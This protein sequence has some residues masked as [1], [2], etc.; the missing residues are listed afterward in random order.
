MA[1]SGITTL[2]R[3]TL[4]A[5]LVG[6]GEPVGAGSESQGGGS[7]GSGG[8]TTA[9]TTGVT[10]A[11]SGGTTGSACAEPAPPCGPWCERA[12]EVLWC[13][14]DLDLL[15]G[16]VARVRVDVDPAGNIVVAGEYRPYNWSI[17]ALVASF[18]PDGALRWRSFSPLSVWVRGVAALADGTIVIAGS[19]RDLV[20]EGAPVLYRFSAEGELLE[21]R[22][23]A[24]ARGSYGDVA[25]A[26][27]GGFV[28][29]GSWGGAVQVER[30]GA[31]LERIWGQ[32]A[33][34]EDEIER[35]RAQQVEVGPCGDVVVAS[36][37]D[38]GSVLLVLRADGSVV[39]RVDSDGKD[40]APYL[41]PVAVFADGRVGALSEPLDG[42]ARNFARLDP[43]TGAWSQPEMWLGTSCCE[44]SSMITVPD[45]GAESV[46]LSASAGD[47]LTRV[48]AVERRSAAGELAWV[49]QN[50]ADPAEMQ[51]FGADLA[52]SDGDATVVLAGWH[53]ASDAPLWLCK[54]I[55]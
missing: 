27:D 2:A 6:C 54:M 36:G 32:S 39:R 35:V 20:P 40:G 11:T 33:P 15:P 43:E 5:A 18:S 13:R 28:A 1:R 55:P 3:S 34:I 46:V 19:I 31:Q 4:C 22:R 53:V 49:L 21:G 29:A 38:R 50:V 14:S 24:D 41:H 12:S 10:E 45:A 26:A 17:R 8:Q 30:R 51:V 25:R 44:L 37:T 48:T 9:V 16:D 47:S 23:V 7:S 42:S 52:R